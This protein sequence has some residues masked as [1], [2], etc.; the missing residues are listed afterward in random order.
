MMIAGIHTRNDFTP[1]L[2]SIVICRAYFTVDGQ[3]I[4]NW[5]IWG[6]APR[7]SRMQAVFVTQKNALPGVVRPGQHAR[8][9]I[10]R[11]LAEPVFFSDFEL[12]I[13]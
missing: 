4:T 2:R 11:R 10:S 1:A 7:A 9:M 12:T 13:R 5:K 3:A 6:L 8:Q